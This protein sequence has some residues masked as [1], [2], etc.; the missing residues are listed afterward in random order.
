MADDATRLKSE[1]AALRARQEALLP[2]LR[3]RN[4]ADQTLVDAVDAV[5]A[6]VPEYIAKLTQVQRSMES[7]ETR[8]AS[9]RKRCEHLLGDE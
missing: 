5:F 2:Q 4:H 3:H 6:Q 8:T 9:M 7:L 1:L